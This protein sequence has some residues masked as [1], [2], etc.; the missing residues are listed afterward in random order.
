L[1]DSL[2]WKR[3]TPA[4]HPEIGAKMRRNC[5]YGADRDAAVRVSVLAIVFLCAT[6][7]MQS[8][9]AVAPAQE[10]QVLAFV[11][12]RVIP[13]DGSAPIENAAFIVRS[14]KITQVGTK[15]SVKVPKEAM[16]VDL[17]GKTVIP[18]IEELHV[19]IGYMK[20]GATDPNVKDGMGVL[21]GHVSKD[22]YTRENVL[23]ELRRFRYYGVG[24]VQS[25]GTD[26]NDLELEIRNEQ[27]SGKLKDD[28]LA[29]LFTA[30]DGIVAYNNGNENGGPPF[31][32][33]VVHE[34]RTPE[35]ARAFVQQEAAKKVD[36]I[37][38]WLDDRYHTKPR[39]A[40]AI[41][42]AIIDEAHKEH[43][44]VIAHIVNL[45]DAK[46]AARAGVDGLAHPPHDT[47]V[48]DEFLHL[49]KQHDVFQCST[50]SSSMP[51]RAW[52]D[53][54]EL[55]ETVPAAYRDYMKAMRTAGA[56]PQ[57]G[58]P[59]AA[60]QGY[61]LMLINEKKESDA[62]IRIVISGDTAGGEGRFPGYTEHR[63]LQALAEAGIP[64]LQVIRDGTQVSADAL[65][66]RD[67]DSLVVGKRADFIVLDANPL[68]EMKNTR[69]ISAVYVDGRAIDRAAM[70]EHWTG[71]SGR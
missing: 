23:D 53:E 60:P 18:M 28:T 29:L 22:Y 20:N 64:P 50:M 70:R 1:L 30:D 25:L 17:S 47:L 57:S 49:M 63:E 43:L 14:G 8:A 45:E 24:A 36:V 34:A 39:M 61:A 27:R 9:P 42:E 10:P 6:V 5:Y 2:S 52:L 11:G 66:L 69:K 31:A 65:G 15:G 21:G 46:A 56:N 37:K 44:R 33:D 71:V 12:G 68:D 40:P 16:Q 67:M 4:A 35:D 13:G 3:D 62:G 26:R 19:H 7:L 38:F 32:R 58:D 48:D 54:P 55:A 51:D 59:H 41:Y